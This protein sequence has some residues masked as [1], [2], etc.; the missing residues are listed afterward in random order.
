MEFHTKSII[1]K[2]YAGLCIRFL[3]TMK[4]FN[5]MRIAGN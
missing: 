5:K 1:S 2:I 3:T 4:E